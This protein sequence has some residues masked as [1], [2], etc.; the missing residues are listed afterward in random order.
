M[1]ATNNLVKWIGRIHS[2]IKTGT[3][4]CFKFKWKFFRLL[5]IYSII[6]LI[7]NFGFVL[8]WLVEFLIVQLNGILRLQIQDPILDSYWQLQHSNHVLLSQQHHIIHRLYFLLNQSINICLWNTDAQQL[9]S[10]ICHLYLI[11]TLHKVCLGRS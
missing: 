2:S 11:M 9:I 1:V 5:V 3:V 10:S 8:W 6:V 4:V 7:L